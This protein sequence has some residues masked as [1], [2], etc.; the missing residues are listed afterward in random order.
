[1]SADNQP[2][3]ESQKDMI[4]RFNA[5]IREGPSSLAAPAGSAA[6]ETLMNNLR[7]TKAEL[8]GADKVIQSLKAKPLCPDC[9]SRMVRVQW[10]CEDGGWVAGWLCE[11][12]CNKYG[13]RLK[14]QND[15]AQRT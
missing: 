1:M 8:S 7:A 3:T 11:C 6:L 2:Y 4:Q 9:N 13:R 5:A 15:Q 10:Q 14:P 12:K